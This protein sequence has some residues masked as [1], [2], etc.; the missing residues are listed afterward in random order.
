MTTRER[1]HK[2]MAGDGDIDQ[3]PVIEWAMWWDKTIQSWEEQ[4]MPKGMNE[5]EIFAYLGLDSIANFWFQPIAPE[6]PR[7]DTRRVV[8]GYI[9]D[10][11]D[12]KRLRKYFLPENAVELLKPRIM[13]TIPRYERG[14]TL[15]WYTLEGFFWF[16]RE[17]FGDV[18]HLYAFYDHPELYHQICE[19]LLEWQIKQID[20]FAQYMK[21]DFMTIAEDMSY[22]KG[23]MI[24]KELFD[25]FMRPYYLRLI[26]EIK[27]YG[28][29]VFVDSDGN[30]EQ[31]LSWFQEAG[32]EGILPLE[33]QAGVDL[34]K[35]RK[36]YP[37]FLFIGGFDKMCLL[38]G[39]EDIRQEFERL[40]PVIRSGK[41]MIGM[42]HQTPP[43]T[44]IENYRY[45]VKLLREYN[46]Y[47]C[48][49]GAE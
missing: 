2:L 5:E 10:E 31:Q 45:Y 8:P 12:Y 19:D 1:F 18:E 47:A 21:A 16:P 20:A 13:E 22:N 14:E 48:K 42:D 25:E 9:K 44:S 40:L 36:M 38:R 23:S 39:K 15:V 3:G 24:S 26:P 49:Y 4:G 7:P 11:A 17:L 6:C 27:K 46:Q 41:Y 28:T 29:K 43:G 32:V 35:F 37:D 34:V 30:V 33:R